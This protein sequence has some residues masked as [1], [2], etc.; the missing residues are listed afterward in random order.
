VLRSWPRIRAEMLYYVQ[1]LFTQIAQSVLCAATI[2][3]GTIAAGAGGNL[4]EGFG[5]FPELAGAARSSLLKTIFLLA[6]LKPNP[7][8]IIFQSPPQGGPGA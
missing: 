8:F 7:V 1:S 6:P 4:S 2:A 3:A 5:P